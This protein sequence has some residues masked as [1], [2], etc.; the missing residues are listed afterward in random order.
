MKLVAKCP[1]SVG[2]TYQEHAKVFKSIPL[3]KEEKKRF[4]LDGA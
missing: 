3:K 1:A 4:G 2:L